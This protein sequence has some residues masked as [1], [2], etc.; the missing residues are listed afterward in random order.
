M[1][2]NGIDMGQKNPKDIKDFGWGEIRVQ[3]YAPDFEAISE[4]F[5]EMAKYAKRAGY[6]GTHPKI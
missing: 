1:Q 2:L 5:G 4:T 6:W 3:G